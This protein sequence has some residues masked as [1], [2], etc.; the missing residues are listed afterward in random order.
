[1]P[2]VGYRAP[3]CIERL[4]VRAEL[5]VAPDQGR[6]A[7]PGLVRLCRSVSM[8]ELAA[9]LQEERPSSGEA[10]RD[11]LPYNFLLRIYD[12]DRFRSIASGI[13]IYPNRW[14]CDLVLACFARC[15]VLGK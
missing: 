2:F 11:L 8:L 5:G 15:G 14:T 13:V 12:C 6:E 9:M 4:W 7:D 3:G 1:M 10:K